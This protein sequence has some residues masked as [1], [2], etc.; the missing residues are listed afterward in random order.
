[1][2]INN[3]DSGRNQNE[4]LTIVAP[5]FHTIEPDTRLTREPT[6]P[7]SNE[8]KIDPK[9]IIPI[10]NIGVPV[11]ATYKPTILGTCF[12]ITHV[13]L[14]NFAVFSYAQ[15]TKSFGLVWMIIFL[16]RK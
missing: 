9:A 13:C 2:S 11:K 10:P 14:G 5:G 12:I 15:I 16:I 7:N 3:N 6:Q 8:I 4:K 1:M